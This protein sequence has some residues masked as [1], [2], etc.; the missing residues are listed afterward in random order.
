MRSLFLAWQAP[1]RGWFPIG[2]LDAEL[3]HYGF[4]YTK[5][6][7]QARKEV[8]FTALPAFPDLKCRYESAELFPLFKNRV[9]DS[10]RKNFGEYL[11]TLGLEHNDPIEILSVTGGERQTDNFEVFPKIEK[12]DD[13][14]FACRFFLHGLRHV[15]EAARARAHSLMPGDELGISLELNNPKTGTAIQLTIP[16]DY[17]ILGWTPHYLVPD[18]LT[19]ISEK[20]EVTA[21]VIRVNEESVPPY[22][23]IL[24][25]FGGTLPES[26]EH[27]SDKRFQLIVDSKGTSHGKRKNGNGRR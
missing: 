16:E 4:G 1:N 3:K 15:S 11:A 22:R 25:E 12:H 13:G 2:R 20:A 27:M 14:S 8:G 9:L 18:L 24:V 21:R 23:R 17:L 7:L 26:F 5:G 6:A 10:N 19:A